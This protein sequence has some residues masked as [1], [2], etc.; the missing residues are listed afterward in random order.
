MTFYPL[1]RDRVLRTIDYDCK[2]LP[3]KNPEFVVAMAFVGPSSYDRDRGTEFVVAM[4][5]VGPSSWDRD[6]GTSSLWPWRS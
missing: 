4:A 1:I 5:F 6:R 2:F 3:D